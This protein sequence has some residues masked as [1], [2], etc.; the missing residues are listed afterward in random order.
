MPPDTAITV[1]H[2]SSGEIDEELFEVMSEL[3]YRPVPTTFREW[4]DHS[5][6]CTGAG[7]V[8]F[9][10]DD[11]LC[12][13]AIQALED[14]AA[15]TLAFVP[16]GNPE[17]GVLARRCHEMCAWPCA[18]GV[19]AQHLR[20]L[21]G[22]DWIPRSSTDSTLSLQEFAHLDLL[23]QAP[24]FIRCLKLIKLLAS[25]DVPVLV[26]GETGTGK[27]LAARALHYLGPRQ[28]MPFVPVNCGAL[29]ETLF[30]NELFGHHPGAFTD[31]R[32]AQMGLV[33]QAEGGS[34]FLDE[35]DSLSSKGQVTLL[36][37]LED[38][39]Y[40]P[41]GGNTL[42]QSDVRIIA[43][44]QTPLRGRVVA[45]EFRGDLLYRLNVAKLRMPPLR[46]RPGDIPLLVSHFV[47]KLGARYERGPKTVHPDTVQWL[48]EQPWPGN[49]RELENVVHRMYLFAEGPVIRAEPEEVGSGY[50]P[51][52]RAGGAAG[53]SPRSFNEA[54]ERTIHDFERR[55]LQSL[56]AETGGNVTQ[57]A[58]LAGKE[59][60]TLGRLL[61]K[62]RIDRRVY[63]SGAGGGA[64]EAPG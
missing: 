12:E 46:E 10:D 54:R 35:I 31:A 40:R 55:Y 42:M 3:G 4:L 36:R 9:V 17:A 6:S 13:W 34:L 44:A 15:P 58:R 26:E 37:F 22:S 19:L 25:F 52:L 64:G 60:R 33:T 16:A 63:E 48:Q 2:G 28:G 59:R 21:E 7:F 51:V 61:K 43:A 38:Y 39:R 49:V 27:E 62:H 5:E 57:A 1:L 41:L 29:P 14:I 8:L 24:A 53:Q 50:H 11:P 30:E 23:G 20:N 47:R 45:R 18:A 56:M 32:V